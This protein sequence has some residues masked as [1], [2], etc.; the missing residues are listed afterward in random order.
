MPCDHSRH[1]PDLHL[2]EP[3]TVAK[4]R[5]LIAHIRCG[6]KR[7]LLNVKESSKS[8]FCSLSPPR[9]A[10]RASEMSVSR[11]FLSTNISTMTSNSAKGTFST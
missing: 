11:L 10:G 9:P 7:L 2:P 1:F 8:T 5:I 3:F 4:I 6:R